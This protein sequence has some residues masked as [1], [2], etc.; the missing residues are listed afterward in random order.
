MGALRFDIVTIFPAIVE[1][2]VKVGVVG[3]G[4]RSGALD[5]VQ[6]S[7]GLH[8][9]VSGGSQ[10]NP[11]WALFGGSGKLALARGAL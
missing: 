7:A 10:V 4:V 11:A 3:R 9:P 2:I 5:V 1:D 6:A 8:V